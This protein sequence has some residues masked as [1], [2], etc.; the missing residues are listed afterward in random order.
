MHFEPFVVK[1]LNAHYDGAFDPREIQWLSLGAQ[2]KVDH[3]Q[4]LL[5]GNG[6]PVA[7]VL[8]VGCGTGAVITEMARRRVGQRHVGIDMT[9][10]QDHMDPV[11]RATDIEFMQYDGSRLPFADKSFDLVYASHVVEHVTDPRSFLAELKRTARCCVFTEVP[12]ELHWRA[13]RNALQRT[14]DIGHINAYTPESYMLLLQTA[15]LVPARAELFDHSLAL[16]AF[17]STP[18]VARVKKALRGG[19]LS[20]SPRVA[21]RCFTY[22]FAVLCALEGQA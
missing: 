2:D 5:A 8:E 21:S 14:L 7:S 1:P 19:L 17:H 15:G 9:N 13:D 20:L 10:P 6:L 4:K 3:L 18:M 16:H 11:A 12:C 22:H